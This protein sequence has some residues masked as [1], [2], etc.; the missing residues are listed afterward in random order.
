MEMAPKLKK[1]YNEM[2]SKV[3][4]IPKEL[5]REDSIKAAIS[6]KVDNYKL[7]GMAEELAK[8]ILSYVQDHGFNTIELKPV[9]EHIQG[10]PFHITGFF[11]KLSGPAIILLYSVAFFV[12]FT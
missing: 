3:K 1:L 4:E 11:V 6:S 5:L 10:H 12:Q 9:M 8:E 2:N 7:N